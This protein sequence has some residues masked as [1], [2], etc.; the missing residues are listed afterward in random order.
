MITGLMGPDLLDSF[1]DSEGITNDTMITRANDDAEIDGI[2]SELRNSVNADSTEDAA[3]LH[4][5]LFELP[6]ASP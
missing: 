2:A 6:T 3:R 1:L 4:A 5:L